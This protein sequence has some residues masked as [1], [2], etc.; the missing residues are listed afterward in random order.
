MSQKDLA[1]IRREFKPDNE[2][3]KIGDV[4]SIYIKGDAKQIIGMEKEYFGM[5]DS[6]KQE[7]YLKNFRKILTGPLDSKV[8]QLDFADNKLGQNPTQKALIT[9]LHSE[10]F[11][12]SVREIAQ[13]IMDSC[14]YEGDYMISFLRGEIYKPSK[15]REGEG[16]LEDDDPL[17]YFEFFMGIVNPVTLPKTALKF[18]FEELVF[19]ADIPMDVTIN[20]SAP[21]DGFMFPSWVD[22]SADVN[23]VVYYA[24]KANNPNLGFIESVLG[25]TI[26]STAKI[27]KEQFQEIVQE[28]AG[29]EIEPEKIAKIYENINYILEKSEEEEVSE[30][31]KVGL[32]EVEKI[33]QVSGVENIQDLDNAFLK[34][35]GSENHEFKAINLIPKFKGKSIKIENNS[36]S[37]SLDPQ[38]LK[39]IKQVRK[40][41]KRYLMIEIDETLN[42]DGFELRTEEFK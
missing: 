22:N 23:K 16:N 24:N 18:D 11:S 10:T 12:E 26:E 31:P 42:L 4:I 15:Q 25:C 39:N 35:T 3:I 41:G 28:V 14:S 19:K 27:E 13:K 21:F 40:D 32:K 20:L 29:S 2:K 8:F 7:L 37:I 1:S 30:P 17:F 9:T 38:D 33:L 6:E 5:M 36:I 34:V